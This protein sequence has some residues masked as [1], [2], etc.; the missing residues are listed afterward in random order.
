MAINETLR[1]A[2][3]A[4]PIE[5]DLAASGA[6]A[7][8]NPNEGRAIRLRAR[9]T[10]AGTIKVQRSDDGG[11]SW[12]DLT[13]A[14]SAWAQFTAN[15]NEEVAVDTSPAALYRLYFTRTSGTVSYRLGH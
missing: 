6:G 1:A 7:S 10:W 4:D 5:E 11:T 15:C 9:G 14:G 2:G 8:F 3:I 13:V 12:D